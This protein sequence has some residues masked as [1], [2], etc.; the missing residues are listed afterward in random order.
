MSDYIELVVAG[1]GG[2]GKKSTAVNFTVVDGIRAWAWL[3]NELVSAHNIRAGVTLTVQDVRALGDVQYQYEKDGKP[4]DL[5]NPKQQLLLGGQMTI[6]QPV[7]E[8]MAKL[9]VVSA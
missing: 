4:V 7:L 3:P 8:P 2:S 6:A 5:V 9:E 1:L